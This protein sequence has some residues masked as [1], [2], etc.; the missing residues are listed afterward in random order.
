M[1][2]SKRTKIV[3][4]ILV[5]IVVLILHFTF[6]SVTVYWQEIANEIAIPALFL[7]YSVGLVALLLIIEV[8]TQKKTTPATPYYSAGVSRGRGKTTHR[9]QKKH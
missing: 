3:L 9:D 5:D 4:L 2:L 6:V 7:I 8:V 1:L